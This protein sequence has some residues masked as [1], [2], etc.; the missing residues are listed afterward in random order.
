MPDTLLLVL[1]VLSDLIL[2]G[3]L[4]SYLYYPHFKKDTKSESEVLKLVHDSTSGE[5]AEAGLK[6]GSAEF[7]GR[8][9]RPTLLILS[10]F[11]IFK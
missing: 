5:V 2:A 9:L 8:D 10:E 3:A 7:R 4:T 11:C 1:Y 6:P